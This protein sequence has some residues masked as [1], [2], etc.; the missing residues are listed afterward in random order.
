MMF[1]HAITIDQLQVGELVCFELEARRAQM[2]ELKH[3]A[4]FVPNPGSSD[5]PYSDAHLYLGISQTR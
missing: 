3:K 5:D 2:C 1:Q 4:R